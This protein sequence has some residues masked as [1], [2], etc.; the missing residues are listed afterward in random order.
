MATT[1]N[2]AASITPLLPGTSGVHPGVSYVVTASATEIS[3][4]PRPMQ[5]LI[6]GLSA[7]TPTPNPSAAFSVTG[8][9]TNAVFGAWVPP[10]LI[11]GQ[12]P[13]NLIVIA[14]DAD[15]QQHQTVQQVI[16]VT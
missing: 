8:T 1:V 15:G 12:G 4:T 10:A 2:L 6:L 11:P 3:G 9:R 7:F 5:V 13:W 16:P 14:V